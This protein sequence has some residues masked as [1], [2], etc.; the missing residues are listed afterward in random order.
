MR[1]DVNALLAR[2]GQAGF[3]YRQFADPI[4]DVEPWPLFAAMLEDERVVGRPDPT[5][6]KIS[7]ARPTRFL[8]DFTDTIAATLPVE[9][10]RDPLRAFLSGL[11]EDAGERR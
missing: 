7:L 5:E 9:P 8:G 11:S 2:L 3:P 4:A 10:L 6:E 1:P